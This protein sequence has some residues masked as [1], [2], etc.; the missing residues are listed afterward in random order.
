MLFLALF[1]YIHVFWVLLGL[2][3]CGF[4]WFLCFA[5]YV[6]CVFRYVFW[7]NCEF[8]ELVV[9]FCIGLV[10]SALIRLL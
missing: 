5:G 6:F 2:V 9:G 1:A 3:S 4:L 7:V 8:L 10:F